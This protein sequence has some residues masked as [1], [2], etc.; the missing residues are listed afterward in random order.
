MASTM[1][2][3]TPWMPLQKYMNG[4]FKNDTVAT[5]LKRWATFGPLYSDYGSYLMRNYPIAFLQ[6][7]I[8]PNTIKFYAPPVEFLEQY[9]TGV[10]SVQ[11]IA[12]KW[13]GYKSIKITSRFKDFNVHV[14]DFLPILAGMLHIVFL[15]GLVGYLLFQGYH[16]Q[17]WLNKAVLLVSCFWLLNFG[18]SVFASPIALRFQLFPIIVSIAFASLYIEYIVKAA[19]QSDIKHLPQEVGSIQFSG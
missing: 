8:W 2:M 12:Q 13:F 5:K 6:Y 1:Y 4:H 17:P 18:F 10:G 7:Y 14:L 11:P 19:R 9:S 15:F 3:W 16:K